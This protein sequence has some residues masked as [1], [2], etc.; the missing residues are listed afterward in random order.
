MP[1]RSTIFLTVMRLSGRSSSNWRK[2][3]RIALRVKFAMLAVPPVLIGGL[4]KNLRFLSSQS[5]FYGTG[6]VL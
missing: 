5:P 3:S 2:A 1:Q 4:R 6:K